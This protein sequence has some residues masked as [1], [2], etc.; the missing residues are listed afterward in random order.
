MKNE[1]VIWGIAPNTTQEDVLFTK[2]ESMEE[3]KR[4]INILT[5]QHNCKE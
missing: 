4:V 1:F 3:A 5:T 2:A